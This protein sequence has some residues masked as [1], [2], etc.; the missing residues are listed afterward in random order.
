MESDSFDIAWIKI[1]QEN[2]THPQTDQCR[3]QPVNKISAI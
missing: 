3:Y 1:S 2:V